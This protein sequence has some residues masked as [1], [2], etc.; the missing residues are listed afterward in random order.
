[1]K[2]P[3]RVQEKLPRGSSRH[4]RKVGRRFQPIVFA[5]DNTSRQ[6]KP[7]RLTAQRRR[8]PRFHSAS[9]KNSGSVPPSRG[10][11]NAE[12]RRL[13]KTRGRVLPRVFSQSRA[14][15]MH[16]PPFD[17]ALLS[18]H[19][20]ALFPAGTGLFPFKGFSHLYYT[21][22][23]AFC[24]PLFMIFPALRTGAPENIT[25]APADARISARSRRPWQTGFWHGSDC[26]RGGGSGNKCRPTDNP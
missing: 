15:R 20:N 25:K 9:R 24:K 14:S 12:Q 13:L 18:A 23:K 22:E 21:R 26:G 7:P 19:G 2:P 1:M 5:H 6:K 10:P 3:R 17:R 11:L 16:N 4:A 8:G